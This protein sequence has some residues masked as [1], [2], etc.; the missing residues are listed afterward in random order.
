[1]NF[2]ESFVP[3][4][5]YLDHTHANELEI[6]SSERCGCLYCG[7]TFSARKVKSWLKDGQNLSAVCPNCGMTKVVGDS[8]GLNVSKPKIVKMS[9]S[10]RDQLSPEEERMGFID[11]C[12]SFGDGAYEDTLTNERLYL[13]YLH[14]LYKDLGNAPSAIALARFY[15][16]GGKFLPPDPERSEFYYTSPAL[17]TDASALFELGRFY[18]IRNHRGDEKKAFECYAKASAIGSLTA[19]ARLACCYLYGIG[20]KPDPYYGLPALVSCFSE[21]YPKAFNGKTPLDEFTLMAASIASCYKIGH[22]TTE[23][24][25]RAGRYYLIAS[26]AEQALFDADGV[27]NPAIREDCDKELAK[28]REQAAG[29]SGPN[30]ILDEDTFY[31]SFYD[32]SD[33]TSPKKLL[34]VE[35][36]DKK[37]NLL[38]GFTSTQRMLII[39]IGND[40]YGD[41]EWAIY[42]A[43][44]ERLSDET[45]F[46]R[47]EFLDPQ[48]V[49]F[50]HD[51][52]LYGESMILRIQFE[53]RVD[54]SEGEGEEE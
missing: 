10:Y 18:E 47:I 11:Y 43:T 12:I 52:P 53:P 46:E 8:S 4:Q 25:F 30:I 37:E 32:Q 22:G 34:H 17:K 33:Y 51:D 28:M 23:D 29:K 16:R 54:P 45:L 20:V 24:A 26:F 41:M 7:S 27:G 35:Y 38:L 21:M 3:H 39:D 15:R 13:Q 19:S 1:M 6:I 49:G 40:L 2:E 5:K 48:T 44:F 36:D 50:F 31:D 42:H 14:A 9:K